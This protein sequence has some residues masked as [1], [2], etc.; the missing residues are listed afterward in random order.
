MSIQQEALEHVKT[1]LKENNY[2]IVHKDDL[3][4]D[5][6]KKLW[7]AACEFMME[8]ARSDKAAAFETEFHK[9]LRSV[10]DFN[11]EEKNTLAEKRNNLEQIELAFQEATATGKPAEIKQKY[12]ERKL[13]IQDLQITTKQFHTRRAEMNSAFKPYVFNITHWIGR[14]PRFDDPPVLMK[15][16]PCFLA[17][18][19]DYYGEQA[20]ARI[21]AVWRVM[22]LPAFAGLPDRKGSQLWHRDRTDTNILKVFAYY[23]DVDQGT[24][25]LEYVPNSLPK[26]SK[27]AEKIPLAE[28]TSY[29]PQELVANLV[30]KSEIVHCEGR[31][32]S[33]LFVDTAGL[34]RGG[35]ATTGERITSQITYLRTA[36][37]HPQTPLLDARTSVDWLSD[38]Q[39]YALT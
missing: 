15:I 6:G 18:A 30:P 17:I 36:P 39:R 35:Y 10:Q 7:D 33:L 26:N 22:A 13:A 23:T 2:A 28:N 4:D 34:H 27:W 38:A 12:G 37:D 32:G 29:P 25:A 5:E 3:L 20:K 31:A 11:E 14:G 8:F 19:N 1:S 16:A 24:G 9:Y 21:P